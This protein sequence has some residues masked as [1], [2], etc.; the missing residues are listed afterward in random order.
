MITRVYAGAASTEIGAEIRRV[1]RC[2]EGVVGRGIVWTVELLAFGRY[3]HAACP[4]IELRTE[5][6]L[7]DRVEDDVLFEH[8]A[9]AKYTFRVQLKFDVFVDLAVDVYPRTV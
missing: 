8:A 9:A 6:K 3:Q 5:F 1:E 4:D 2:F 7:R